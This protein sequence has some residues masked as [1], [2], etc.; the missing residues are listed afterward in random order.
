[1]SLFDDNAGRSG[2]SKVKMTPMLYLTLREKLESGRKVTYTQTQLDLTFRKYLLE[3]KGPWSEKQI[4]D[5]SNFG[6]L[7][8]DYLLKQQEKFEK[9]RQSFSG[10][11]Q[12]ERKKKETAL[13][14]KL[15]L[16]PLNEKDT[17]K[18]LRGEMSDA[19]KGQKMITNVDNAVDVANAIS[20]IGEPTTTVAISL[21]VMAAQSK[22]KSAIIK[23]LLDEYETK[24]KNPSEKQIILY[25]LGLTMGP[26][27][28]LE[29]KDRIKDLAR[30]EPDLEHGKS[31]NNL[32][33]KTE[34][35]DVTNKKIAFIQ[36]CQML[37][38]PHKYAPYVPVK[39]TA[40]ISE[41]SLDSGPKYFMSEEEKR[42]RD[43]A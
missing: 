2:L 24:A 31:L 27:D 30:K 38:G 16:M 15:G 23:M 20:M 42:A 8:T 43:Q 18:E 25:A 4:Q 21:I 3:T 37:E 7:A 40:L 26:E 41:L 17:P 22:F 12:S 5:M 35:R 33:P 6:K 19:Q 10:K 39:K 32:G 34:T 14:K 29:H 13:L 28:K 9:Q 1:M 11:P 36:N